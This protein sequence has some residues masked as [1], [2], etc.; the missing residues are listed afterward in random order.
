MKQLRYSA[1]VFAGILL[2]NSLLSAQQAAVSTSGAAVV[3]RLVKV[4]G[5]AID[6]GKVL[7]GVTGATFAIYSE[8]TGGLSAL[9]GNPERAG[10]QQGQ[11]HRATGRVGIYGQATGVGY[12]IIGQSSSGYGL[13]GASSCFPGVGGISGSN[14]A[15]YGLSESNHGVVGQTLNA[16]AYG[17]YGTNTEAGG[18]GVYGLAIGV[19]GLRLK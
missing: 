16:N 6:Q 1:V 18:V 13:F 11:L 17:V 12:G 19:L 8:E 5:K 3:P 4:S 9:A 7:T 2:L 14:Y 10:R 15:I